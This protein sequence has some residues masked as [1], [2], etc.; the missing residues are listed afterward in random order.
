MSDD[1]N[2]VLDVLWKQYAL[3]IDLYKHYLTILVQYNVFFYAVTGAIVSFALTHREIPYVRYALVLPLIMATGSSV[4]FLVSVKL[5]NVSARHIDSLVVTF[6]DNVY[7][8]I[9]V[10]PETRVLSGT[11][12][13]FGVLMA[14]VA[15]ALI[16]AFFLLFRL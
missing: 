12:I 8:G 1:R 4:I 6:R 7:P 15:L 13:L 16:A 2:A 14:I 11:L 3:H 10:A 5:A 9:D